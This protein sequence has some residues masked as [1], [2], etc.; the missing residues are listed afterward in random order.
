[1]VYSLS[2]PKTAEDI[3]RAKKATWLLDYLMGQKAIIQLS[4]VS[5]AEYLVKVPVAKHA[6]AIKKLE[7]RFRLAPFNL[8]AAS[9]AADIVNHSKQSTVVV[10]REGDRPCLMADTKILA[11]LIASGMQTFYANDERIRTLAQSYRST[12]HVDGL[13]PGPLTILQCQDAP[14]NDL[15]EEE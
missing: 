7:T 13:P 2:I 5:V 6:A 12:L 1:M 15:S 4:Y 3:D 10:R 14:E 8:E 9:I 11:S